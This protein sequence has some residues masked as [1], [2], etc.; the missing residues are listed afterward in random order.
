MNILV[1]DDKGAPMAQALIPAINQNIKDPVIFGVAM[2]REG[3]AQMQRAGAD[4]AL[5]GPN[6]AA[7]GCRRAD[8]I[9]MPI[10]MS[11]SGGNRSVQRMINAI[12]SSKAKKISVPSGTP[13]DLGKRVQEVVDQLKLIAGAKEPPKQEQLPDPKQEQSPDNED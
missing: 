12:N 4:L 5:S 3:M 11:T 10:E 6:A 7:T 1:I 13:S 2:D 8:I 9:I